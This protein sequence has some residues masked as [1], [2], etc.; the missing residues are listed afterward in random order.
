MHPHA[1]R[2]RHALPPFPYVG[3]CHRCGRPLFENN[4][5]RIAGQLVYCDECP[6]GHTAPGGL[7]E[8]LRRFLAW[9]GS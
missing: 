8:A 1:T 6:V 4:R 7:R 3:A 5:V 2:V 9:L